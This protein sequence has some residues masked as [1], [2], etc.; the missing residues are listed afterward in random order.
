M[1]TYIDFTKALKAGIDSLDCISTPK[2]E[3]FTNSLKA[4]STFT[5]I[6]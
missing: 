4:K 5:F 6:N 1:S 2:A 3:T